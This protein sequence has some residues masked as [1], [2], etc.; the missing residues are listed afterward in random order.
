MVNKFYSSIVLF[1]GSV[2]VSDFINKLKNK[3]KNDK[4]NKFK[5]LFHGIKLTI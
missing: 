2:L 3:L 5:I 1:I 4:K